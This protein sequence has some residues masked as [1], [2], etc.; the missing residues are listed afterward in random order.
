LL[1]SLAS[2]MGLGVATILDCGYAECLPDW[3]RDWRHESYAKIYA[4]VAG[5]AECENDAGPERLVPGRVYFFPPHQRERHRC[6]LR[7]D[8]HW[9]HLG[10]DSPL[11][12]LRLTRLRRIES[13]PSAEWAAWKPVYTRLAEFARTR[14]EELELRIQAMALHAFAELFERH[15]ESADAEATALRE[16]FAPALGL[17]DAEFR[18]NP[19]L[20]EIAR[21]AGLSVAHFHREFR[22]AFRVSPHGYMLR[23]RMD[24]AQQL[25]SRTPQT[26]GEVAA[27]CGYPDQFY[28]SRVFK[29]WSQ[30]SP[31]KYRASRSGTP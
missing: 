10:I 24:L 19:S 27:A 20:A 13:W 12:D 8:V 30:L 9:V 17:M 14:G 21:S 29:R 15:P 1:G 4:V 3:S 31:E 6:R 23:R 16:R 18:R 28:F 25:L 2:G 5:G 7:F 22:R 11:L 26:V